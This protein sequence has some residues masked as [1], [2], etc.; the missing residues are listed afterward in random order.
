MQNDGRWVNTKYGLGSM[1]RT[2]CSPT[3]MAMA[4]TSILQREVLPTEVAE[5]LYNKTDQFNKKLKGTSGMGIIYASDHF[6]VKWKG[7]GTKEKFIEAL[8][9]GKIVY[10]SMQKGKYATPSYNHSILL[11]NYNESTNQTYAFDPLKKDNNGWNSINQ[12]WNEQCMDP[13]DRLG[14]FAFYS[15]EEK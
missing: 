11:V 3:A 10:A 14:G 7:I 8:K 9:S 5:Y 12:I 13:D 6:G 1:G 15:L 2:G 4:Y